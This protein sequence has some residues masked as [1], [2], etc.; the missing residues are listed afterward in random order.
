MTDLT[1]QA[2]YDAALARARRSAAIAEQDRQA[3]RQAS[4]AL[5]RAKQKRAEDAGKR[6]G[7]GSN[8]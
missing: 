6:R 1:E 8:G 2:A 3:A 5:Q 7:G 4:Y